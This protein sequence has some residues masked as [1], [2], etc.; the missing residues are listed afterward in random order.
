LTRVFDW[1]EDFAD[2]LSAAAERHPWRLLGVFS[3]VYFAITMTLS[4]VRRF[5]FD[6]LFTYHI[7]LLPTLGDIS[8]ALAMSIDKHPPPFFWVSRA[9]ASLVGNVHV[10]LRLPETIGVWLACICLFWFVTNRSNVLYGT[11]ALMVPLVT[12]SYDY[13]YEARPYGLALGMIGIALV[14]W[15]L[16]ADDRW[17]RFSVPALAI[18]LAAAVSSSYYAVLVLPAF[19]IAETVRVWLRRKID[20]GVAAALAAATAVTFLYVSLARR[21][22]ADLEAGRWAAPGR[23]S[24]VN[25]YRALIGD[26]SLPLIA[27]LL[28]FAAGMIAA[29]VR[30]LR[31]RSDPARFARPHEIAMAAGLLLLPV[32]LYVVGVLVTHMVAARYALATVIGFAIL[33]TLTLYRAARGSPLVAAATLTIL[34]LSF[35][36]EHVSHA[37]R[38]REDFTRPSALEALLQGQPTDLP[39]AVDDPLRCLEL[40]FYER[41]AIATRLRYL[42]DPEGS[43]R[44]GPYYYP[45]KGWLRLKQFI[46]LGADEIGPFRARHS[47]YLLFTGDGPRGFITQRLV[48]SGAHLEALSAVGAETLYLV[49]EP[50]VSS[51]R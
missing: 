23:S 39:I 25:A 30:R 24:I 9:G 51:T 13:A 45:G 27:L 16:A 28:L 29:P 26:V 34:V 3:L 14:S 10:G 40:Q 43:L 8:R 35:V 41:K 15:Q 21:G 6:E 37:M 46:P 31:D 44:F 33:A 47:R 22:V 36:P 11:I 17:R 5:W 42:V 7:A 20:V 12:R 32:F 1:T 48:E 50:T 18:G 19:F 49:T 2:G 4:S 38:L